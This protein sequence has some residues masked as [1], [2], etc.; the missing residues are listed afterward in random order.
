MPVTN[1]LPSRKRSTRIIIK[2]DTATKAGFTD[3]I[4]HLVEQAPVV[5]EDGSSIVEEEDFGGAKE[6]KITQQAYIKKRSVLKD[7]QLTDRS[8]YIFSKSYAERRS[9][10]HSTRK[11]LMTPTIGRLRRER[12][13]PRRKSAAGRQPTVQNLRRKPESCPNGPPP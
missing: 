12:N 6:P 13:L 9:T 10:S 5:N 2:Q 3:D 7:H 11:I 1:V 4:S 8:T